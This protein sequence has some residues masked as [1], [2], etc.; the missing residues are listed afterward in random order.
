MRAHSGIA[1]RGAHASPDGKVCLDGGLD[2]FREA[3][4]FDKDTLFN[5]VDGEAEAYFPYGFRGAVSVTYT[6]GNDKTKSA[7]VELYEMGSLLDAYGIY[8]SNR[9]T[10]SQ[11]LDVGAEGFTGTTQV[12]F[13]VN[14]YFVKARVNSAAAAGELSSFV[15]AVAKELPADKKKPAQLA[16]VAI[17]NLVP[18]SDQYIGQSVLGYACWPKGLV[19][20][21]KTPEASARIFV[22]MTGSASEAATALKEYLREAAQDAVQSVN[23]GDAKVFTLIDPMQKG[24]AVS[25]AGK[26]LIGAANMKDPK[27]QG[28]LS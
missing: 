10:D 25:Q 1:R 23:D 16:L 9:E 15:K 4:Y 17:P 6:K 24:L 13:Y 20:Q 18:Q 3:E 14:R 8:S 26:Y 28:L 7:S 11:P 22:V 21:I 12:M 2:A 27:S 5:L 19:A